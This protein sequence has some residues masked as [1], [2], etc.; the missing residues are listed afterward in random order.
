MKKTVLLVIV[1]LAFAVTSHAGSIK[2]G[3]FVSDLKNGFHQAQSYWAKK[4]AKEKYGADGAVKGPASSG[5]TILFA[6]DEARFEVVQSIN[7]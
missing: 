6:E 3:Y 1:L 2:I 4:Y 7:G 5:L